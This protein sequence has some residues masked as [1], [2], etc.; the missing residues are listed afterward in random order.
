MLKDELE[1]NI[2]D[3]LRQ[4]LLI[5]QAIDVLATKLDADSGVN[6]TDYKATID[7]ITL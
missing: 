1:A 2:S 6:D 7:A 3:P 4:I 5:A